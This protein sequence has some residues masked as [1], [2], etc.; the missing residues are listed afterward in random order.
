M[1]VVYAIASRLAGGG[2]G[3]IAYHAARGLHR[4]KLLHRLLC[5]SFRP[6]EIPREKIKALGLPS[7]VLRKLAVF[8]RSQW[9]HYL[10][11]LIFDIWASRLLVPAD[12]FHV[13]GNFGLRSL[14]RA[15]ALGMITVIE[16]ASSHPLYQARLLQEEY[17]HWGL[18]FQIPPASL[19][20]AL[21]ELQLADYVLIPSDFVRYSFFQEN[22]PENRLLQA[23]FGADITRFQPAERPSSRLFRVLFVGQIGIRK[24]IPYLLEAWQ[25]LGWRDAE[26]ILVGRVDARCKVLLNRWQ[27]LPGVKMIGYVPD[28]VSLYQQADVFAFPTVEEGSALV[29]YEALACGLPVITTPNAGSVIRDEIEGFLL[30]VRDVDGIAERLERLRADAQLRY[31]MGNAARRRAEEFTWQAYGDN[32]ARLY[33]QLVLDSTTFH[34]RNGI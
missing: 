7:R 1:K 16:R 20:R 5:G 19:H 28:P 11:S 30:P 34:H 9:L 24:G 22:F 14:Q 17:A 10:D 32:L 3:T 21:A 15:N 23:P 33:R 6:T 31:D 4:H 2:I 8:D 12:L 26:L 27:G 18:K 13:W 25:Q 29:V